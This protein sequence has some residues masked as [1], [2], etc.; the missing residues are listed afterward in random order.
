MEMTM[1]DAT[2]AVLERQLEVAR[3]QSTPSS[4]LGTGSSTAG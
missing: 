3:S 2:I 4:G 1:K